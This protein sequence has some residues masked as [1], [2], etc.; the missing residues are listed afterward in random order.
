MNQSFKLIAVALLFSFLF[1]SCSTMIF[2]RKENVKFQSFPSGAEIYINDKP[3]GLTTPAKIEIDK[4]DKLE[5]PG[6][7]G[8]KYE[9]RK[10]GYEPYIVKKKFGFHFGSF[11]YGN[12]WL[13][14]VAAIIYYPIALGNS[15][16]I[17]EDDVIDNAEKG[18]LNAFFIAGV[19][20]LTIDALSGTTAKLPRKINA[21]LIPKGQTSPSKQ[22]SISTEL[23]SITDGKPLTEHVSGKEAKG[24]IGSIFRKNKEDVSSLSTIDDAAAAAY[25]NSFI[26]ISKSGSFAITKSGFTGANAQVFEKSFIDGA[27]SLVTPSANPLSNSSLNTNATSVDPKTSTLS[28]NNSREEA[29]KKI[30]SDKNKQTTSLANKSTQANK[31][32]KEMMNSATATG[33]KISKNLNSQQIDSAKLT[34]R[35]SSIYTLMT[36]KEDRPYENVIVNAFGNAPLSEKFNDHNLGPYRIKVNTEQKDDNT[37]ISEY[38]NTNNIA[39]DVVAKWF[40]RSAQGGFN[41]NLVAERGNY[42]ASEMRVNIAKGSARG[43]ASI[44]DAGEELIGNT[45]I[46]VNDFKFTNKEEVA[47][48]AKT[49][50]RLAKMASGYIPGGGAVDKISTVG[51]AAATVA[52]KGYIIRTTS[53]LYRLVWNDSIA[54]VFYNEMW[55]EDGKIDP[56][57]KELFENTDLFT[58]KYVG[59]E[60]A[61]ADLQSTIFTDKSEEDLI[62]I[63][64]TK[65]VDASIAKLQRKFEEFRTKSPLYTGYPITA[66]IGLKE[67]LESG[68]RFEVLERTLDETGK[69]KY[70]RK[71]VITVDGSKIWDNRYMAAEE[72][73]ASNKGN[74]ASNTELLDRTYFNGSEKYYS[75]MLIRQIK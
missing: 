4:R 68:D 40:N 47:A 26:D 19:S 42:D 21:D 36:N 50:L 38:L 41:M 35:R 18:A 61:I 11:I 54:A 16:Y 69:T 55:T 39:R 60:V 65:A 73:A 7:K 10:E 48:K 52:G 63:A 56:K 32:S 33:T 22:N 59:Y 6:F 57:K 1:S 70:I 8:M 58:L 17:Y 9:L 15:V 23:L 2:G 14:S 62:R 66:K 51:I 43:L 28:Y 37:S 27:K 67:G 46:I 53:H 34:F 49:G 64:T 5:E 71:G 29:L 44:S 3:T 31:S 45:F 72:K 24:I 13:A 20:A 75:G 25:V 74:S 30:L 12:V